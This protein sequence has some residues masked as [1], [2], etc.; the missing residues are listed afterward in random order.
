MND[1]ECRIVSL[2]SRR[3]RC[4]AEHVLS[5][6]EIAVRNPPWVRRRNHV[7]LSFPLRDTVAIEIERFVRSPQGQALAS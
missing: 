3:L 2:P 6:P 5:R 1:V 4:L 7:R